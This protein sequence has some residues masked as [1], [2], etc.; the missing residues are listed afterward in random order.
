MTRIYAVNKPSTRREFCG[1]CK[2]RPAEWSD[3]GYCAMCN[4][5]CQECKD[6]ASSRIVW[7]KMPKRQ[8]PSSPPVEP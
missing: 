2:S 6:E 3:V 1:V 8:E 4:L 5:Y 7:H